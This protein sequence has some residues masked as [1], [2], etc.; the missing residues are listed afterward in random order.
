M[1][2][3]LICVFQVQESCRKCVWLRELQLEQVGWLLFGD[4]HAARQSAVGGQGMFHHTVMH[5]NHSDL[6]SHCSNAGAVIRRTTSEKRS[7]AMSRVGGTK[8]KK[9]PS[10]DQKRNRPPDDERERGRL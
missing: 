8:V 1:I 6:D 9:D 10:D 4:K 2:L 5:L 7:T 3:T